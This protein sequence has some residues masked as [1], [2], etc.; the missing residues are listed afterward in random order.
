MSDDRIR[1]SIG[2]LSR[3]TG[4]PVRTIRFYSDEG[5]VPPVDRSES[6][7]RQY[8]TE[9]LA[10]LELVRTLRDLDVDL[11][12]IRRVLAR[13]ATLA[14]VART[15]VEALG[16]QIRILKL[17]RAVFHAIAERPSTPTEVN[18][19]HQLA[20]L[21]AEERNAI[22]SDFFDD[23]FGGLSIDPEFEQRMR[24]ATPELPEEPTPE[25][26]NAWIELA[27]LTQDPGFRARI[28]QMS[29]Q[30]SASRNTGEEAPSPASAQQMMQAI[31]EQAGAALAA[32]IR[33]DAPEARPYA[34]AI[35]TA[36][37]GSRGVEDSPVFR[38]ELA[39]QLA[40][41]TDARAERYWQLMAIINGWPPV[42]TMTPAMLWTIAALRAG[43]LDTVR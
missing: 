18:L 31:V 25:Q 42:P 13:E 30:H 17:R 16:A 2:E 15:Q 7:Y 34:D 8:D 37:A 35:A 4:L 11:S 12:T 32:G 33:P 23:V 29:E 28:R 43:S 10:R 41:G 21:S 9:S 26:V 3:R 14:D 19:M 36:A 39:D 40:I 20:R 27:E 22:I 6:G 38:S 5:I 24:S 1:F